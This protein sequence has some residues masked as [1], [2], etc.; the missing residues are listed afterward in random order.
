MQNRNHWTCRYV[1]VY[2]PL[3]RQPSLFGISLKIP[4][5]IIASV[6]KTRVLCENRCKFI[7]FYSLPVIK[8][9]VVLESCFID[10]WK[11]GYGRMR[12]VDIVIVITSSSM[13]AVVSCASNRRVRFLV[14]LH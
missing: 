12:R 13:N 11:G 2:F 3:L 4:V 8:G 10:F 5:T 14:H 9:G 6:P 1:N 7:F